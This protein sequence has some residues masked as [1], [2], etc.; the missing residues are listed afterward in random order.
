MVAG[1]LIVYEG[2]E[3]FLHPQPIQYEGLAIFVIL[4]SIGVSYWVFRHN[5]QAAEHTESSA[6]HVN[7]LHFL[8]DVMAS[9]G[10]LVGLILLN[11]QGGFG[12]IL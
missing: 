12:W 2:V 11:L 4:I 6:L 9:G 3:H 10:V 5:S 8:S 1:V 7:A